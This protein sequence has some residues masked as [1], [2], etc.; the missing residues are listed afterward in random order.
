MKSVECKCGIMYSI[1]NPY[2]TE[3]VLKC[4]IFSKGGCR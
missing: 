2:I 3:S 4:K 1:N